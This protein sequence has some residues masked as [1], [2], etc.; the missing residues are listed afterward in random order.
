MKSE[1]VITE[2]LEAACP[3]TWRVRCNSGAD[4]KWPQSWDS[5]IVIGTLADLELRFS[6]STLHRD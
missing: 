4:R 5:K 3:H 2:R 6:N 1:L